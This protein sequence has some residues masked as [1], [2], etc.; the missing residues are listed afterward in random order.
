MIQRPREGWST[1]LLLL[2]LV[3]L[4]ATAV[5]EARWVDDLTD[6]RPLAFGALLVSGGVAKMRVR[7]PQAWLAIGL[8]GLTLAILQVN[9]GQLLA[10][11]TAW[12][13]TVRRSE[14]TDETLPFA[15]ALLLLVWFGVAFVGWMTLRLQRP[16]PA[17]LLL[18]IGIGLN[19]RFG[20]IE[21]PLILLYAA[22][23][24]GLQLATHFGKTIARWQQARVTFSAE[25]RQN[26]QVT[27]LFLLV[28]LLGLGYWLA[29]VR[30]VRVAQA[31][32]SWEPIQ[33]SEVWLLKSFAGVN[34]PWRE[35]LGGS[36]T[37]QGFLPRA[38]LL[39]NAPELRET[40][41]M[42]TQLAY[43]GEIRPNIHWRAVS[44][45]IYTGRGWA[46]SAETPRSFPATQPLIPASNATIPISQTVE[47]LLD[48]RQVRYT[49]GQPQQFDHA[50]TA[51]LGHA[52]ALIWVESDQ[53]RYQA[54]S[55]VSGAQ[56]AELNTVTTADIDPTILTHYTTL[57]RIPARV[58]ALAQSLV[59]SEM[60]PFQQAQ[61]IEAYLKQFPYSL[62]L[63]AP[64]LGR[65]PVDFF[66]FDQQ[67]GYCDY[68]ASAMV[69]LARAV[70]LP[71]RLGSGF[72]ARAETDVVYQIDGHS[73]AEIY[74]GDYGWI[75]FEPTAGFGTR[76]AGTTGETANQFV[77][78]E[79]G[80]PDGSSFNLPPVPDQVVERPI[81]GRWR[82]LLGTI[83]ITLLGLVIRLWRRPFPSLDEQFAFLHGLADQLN[84]PNQRAQT[85]AEFQLVLE[86]RLAQ[87][88]LSRRVVKWF[89]V[90][91]WRE[92]IGRF[93]HAITQA[94]ATRQYSQSKTATGVQNSAE[95]RHLRWLVWLLRRFGQ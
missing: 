68:Y 69:V 6:I 72:I 74:F 95:W 83:S 49:F 93:S 87:V 20:R 30:S 81:Q 22:T 73:W 37:A 64:P 46:R 21:Q 62:D 71:A 70:G 2:L 59:T 63:A 40:V 80:M 57:P 9:D 17:L 61:A 45:D 3:W 52:D 75:E 92:E 86:R 48:D 28:G 54:V 23:A 11:L 85:P 65:D 8:V 58:T 91:E 24:L 32:A 25:I 84:V 31:F 79:F 89:G 26:W 7:V 34:T 82:L 53:R 60:T 47:W 55:L 27:N 90:G 14:L 77:E 36:S 42:R 43:V 5:Q 66:L 41:V 88:W 76:A 39:G 44:Y 35:L 78:D 4:A 15:L 1:Y 33:R 16:L 56:S 10:R 13:T 18:S 50:T 94:F 38:Y 51:H 29:D 12:M 19:A 67:R